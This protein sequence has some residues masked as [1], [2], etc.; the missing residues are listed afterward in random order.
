MFRSGSTRWSARRA[1]CGGAGLASVLA[2]AIVPGCAS[3]P[4][5]APAADRADA[6]SPEI[7][8][9]GV[10]D[11]A[12]AFEADHW[13]REPHA[14]PFEGG[15]IYVVEFWATWCVACINGFPELADLQAEY[16][17]KGVVVIAATNA[18]DRGCTLESATAMALDPDRRMDFGVAFMDDPGVYRAWAR[19]A[20]HRGIPTALVVDR[21]GRL[22]HVGYERPPRAV[23]E[24]LL[25]GTFDMEAAAERHERVMIT[26]ATVKRYEELLEGGDPGASAFAWRA[27]EGPTGRI[28]SG[29]TAIAELA[30]FFTPKGTE[31]DLELALAGARLGYELRTDPTDLWYDQT[32]AEAEFRAGNVQ[33]AIEVCEWALDQEGTLGADAL[34]ERLAGYRQAAAGDG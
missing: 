7:P 1:A 24:E 12:P 32:L 17:D 21:S 28:S 31:P 22:A 33:R 6:W 11:R 26:R 15:S 4:G 13:I 27:L 18:D 19:A 29:P 9:L 30:L 23:V 3:P 20:G 10:G 16:A 8:P 25:A 34:R 2:A 5:R 14:R